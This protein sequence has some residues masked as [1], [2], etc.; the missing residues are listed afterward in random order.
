MHILVFIVVLCY[1]VISPLVIFP[2]IIYFG[3]AWFVYKNQLLYVYVKSS[4][5]HGAYWYMAWKRSVVGLGVFQFLTAG[6][7]SA[8]KAPY[9]AVFVGMLVPLTYIFFLYCEGCFSKHDIVVPLEHL[10]GKVPSGEGDE[11]LPFDQDSLQRVSV[12]SPLGF[13]AGKKKEHDRYTSPAISQPLPQLWIP[14]YIEHLVRLEEDEAPGG[15]LVVQIEHE[16][17]E[18]ELVKNGDFSDRG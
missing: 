5:S 16:A 15:S 11:S 13:E 7:L 1:S 12:R 17:S 18:V 6:L 3:S 10:Y 2:G 4:E 8:K 9:P 14:K